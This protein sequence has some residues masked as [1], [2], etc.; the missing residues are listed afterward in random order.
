MI[1]ATAEVRVATAAELFVR[2][3]FTIVRSA[4][5]ETVL[6]TASDRA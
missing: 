2:E 5:L 6:Y 3:L 4:L 1:P